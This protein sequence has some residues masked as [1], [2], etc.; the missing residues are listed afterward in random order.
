MNWMREG[1][2]LPPASGTDPDS[3]R[4]F[5]PWVI[6][7]PD[8]ILR[9]WYS[10]H[11][12]ATWRILEAV[13][14]ADEPWERLGIAIDAGFAGETDDFG[15]ESPCVVATPAG[16]LMA[17]G[18]S[19]GVVTRLH[20]AT[21]DDGRRWMPQGTI[22]QREIEDAVAAT[23]PC[24]VITG[25]RWW[26]FYSG[27]VGSSEGG[28]GSILGAVSVSGASWDR[29]GPVLG[30]TAK[31]AMVSHPCVVDISRTYYMFF[32]SHDGTCSAIALATSPDGAF[33]QRR[34]VT[35]DALGP[36][37]ASVH[38]PC[39]MRLGNG[40]VHMWYAALRAD[41]QELR[42]RICSARRSRPPSP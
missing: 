33:W 21:S 39:V 17:Y 40:A 30:S 19:D 20:I 2:V 1:E 38:A 34:G 15:V 23:D 3:G 18:G 42:Y 22:M 26:L 37:E 14:R 4:A 41:D 5:R 13:K 36:E 31:D 9:M 16:Y 35:L 25:S 24:V 8:G 12:G 27:Y 7:E 32:G 28:K 6:E 11:D 10:G 29:L